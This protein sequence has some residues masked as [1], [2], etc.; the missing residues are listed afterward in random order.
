[1]PYRLSPVTPSRMA[2]RGGNGPS[3]DRVPSISSRAV[4][5]VAGHGVKN[6]RH[7]PY[8]PSPD[9]AWGM[10]VMCHIARRRTRR[11]RMVV[12]CS[13]A[14]R[15]IACGI[16]RRP[17]TCRHVPAR[18]GDLMSL[19]W[20]RS[21]APNARR[22]PCPGPTYACSRRRQPLCCVWFHMSI[23]WCS[24]DA[25]PAARLRRIVGPPTTRHADAGRSYTDLPSCRTATSAHRSP[26]IGIGARENRRSMTPMPDTNQRAPITTHGYR[27]AGKPAI[28]DAHAGHGPDEFDRPSCGVPVVPDES[29]RPSCGVPVVPDESDSPSCGVP[30][31]VRRVPCGPS[32]GQCPSCRASPVP[33]RVPV[34]A[35]RAAESR[36]R[37]SPGRCPSCRR[38][39]CM[40]ESR[41]MPVVPA[42]PVHGRVPVTARHL[43]CP[44]PTV[45]C[46]RRRQPLCTNIYSFTVSWRFITA[47]SAARLRRDVGPPSPRHVDAEPSGQSGRSRITTYHWG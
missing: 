27:C 25:R 35:R 22:R 2:R 38:V 9:M 29:E 3:P 20:S 15:R 12:A 43:P 36:A 18:V 17:I 6:G 31:G 13:I 24:I 5:P 30:V 42:S 34:N 4:S 10:G 1:M 7:V 46:S 37:T 41:S 19:R 28:H 32:P 14:G 33:T 26:R 16:A 8:R 11:L 44:G 47:R 40:G 39:P 23:P 45:A 21:G